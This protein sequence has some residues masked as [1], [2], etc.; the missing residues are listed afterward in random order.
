MNVRPHKILQTANWLAANSAL[1]REQG[2][3]FSE[4]RIS[5]YNLSLAQSETD[6]EDLSQV[7]YQMN[8]SCNDEDAVNESK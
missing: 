3:S 7:N 6:G 4:D 5:S 1:Y 2:V 8:S